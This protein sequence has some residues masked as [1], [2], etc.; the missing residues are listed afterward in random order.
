MGEFEN[1]KADLVGKAKEAAGNA[2]DNED[3]AN[4]GKL[5]EQWI[6]DTLSTL[7][8]TEMADP[9]S[10]LRACYVRDRPFLLKVA[11][12]GCRCPR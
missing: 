3:L 9:H 7:L 8:L 6:A 12:R 2:T 1:K 10:R 5:T 11:F 4:E